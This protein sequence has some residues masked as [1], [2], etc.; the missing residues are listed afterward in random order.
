MKNEIR[1][2]DGKKTEFV[3]ENRILPV[4]RIQQK[5]RSSQFQGDMI[6]SDG[7]LFERIYQ[8]LLTW[9]P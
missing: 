9:I 3:Y 7:T 5:A 2:Q 4:D 8:A 1:E 6:P